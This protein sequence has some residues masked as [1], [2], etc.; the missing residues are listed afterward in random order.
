MQTPNSL[1]QKIFKSKEY[2]KNIP[3]NLE[4]IK[5]F[6]YWE[7]PSK[8]WPDYF[9]ATEKNQFIFVPI[10]W[11]Y[12]FRQEHNIY[13]F[14]SNQ[15]FNLGYIERL[16]T[17][18]ER[19]II[20]FIPTGP[21]PFDVRGG[22]PQHLFHQSVDLNSIPRVVKNSKNE[23][24]R[25]PSFYDQNMYKEYARFLVSLY[26]SCKKRKS[27]VRIKGLSAGYFEDKNFNTFFNDSS[28]TF[29]ESFE[30]YLSASEIEDVSLSDVYDFREMVSNLFLSASE[31][32]LGAYWDG[33]LKMVFH[34]AK[35]D[36]ILY[37]TIF[38]NVDEHYFHDLQL[39]V[40]DGYL[41]STEMVNSSHE[42]QVF[43]RAYSE[44]MNYSYIE[45]IVFDDFHLQNNLRF[46]PLI[47]AKIFSRDKFDLISTGILDYFEKNCSHHYQIIDGVYNE[48]LEQENESISICFSRYLGNK[49]F[50]EILNNFSEGANIILDLSCMTL[51]HRK[52]LE[53]FLSSH[54]TDSQHINLIG[55]VSYY[56]LGHGN[57][58]TFESEHFQGSN[59]SK[60]NHFWG[61]LLSVFSLRTL[62][63]DLAHGVSCFVLKREVTPYELNYKEVRRVFL[64]N[65]T[66]SSKSVFIHSSKESAFL[67]YKNQLSTEVTSTPKGVEIEMEKNGSVILDFGIIKDNHEKRT[68]RTI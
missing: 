36:D 63:I 5:W 41:T 8:N 9:E 50:Q 23:L 54:E 18:Y 14:D 65:T 62:K 43:N 30:R 45:S 64:Y 37:S 6:R 61:R 48:D 11:G 17:E 22:V 21:Y 56:Q 25:I 12:H 68:H 27:K 32:Y 40:K 24:C 39:A 29:L 3:E 4:T 47:F 38:K 13:D 60:R 26:E 53:L 42:D 16:A 1:N 59:L 34:G 46:T 33:D 28:K 15:D 31:K 66:N 49:E 58:V 35:S 20:F 51:D 19:E 44:M 7:I 67:K 57:L 52:Q 10:H 55:P 2:F